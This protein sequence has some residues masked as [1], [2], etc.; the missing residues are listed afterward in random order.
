MPH[1][2]QQKRNKIKYFDVFKK[3]KTEIVGYFQ[4]NTQYT[5]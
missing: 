3:N 2:Q 5:C 1:S 4:F